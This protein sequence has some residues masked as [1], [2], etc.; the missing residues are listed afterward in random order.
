VRWERSRTDRDDGGRA[1]SKRRPAI[2][3]I[4]EAWKSSSRQNA[5]QT[6][7]E[8]SGSDPLGGN[9]DARAGAGKGRRAER[10]GDP[11][12]G[13]GYGGVPEVQRRAGQGGGS[14]REWSPIPELAGQARSVRRQEA[15]RHRRAICR[16]Q[17]TRRR[18]LAVAGAIS[19]RGPRVAQAGTLR[20]RGLRGPSDFGVR[21]NVRCSWHSD[22]A[23]AYRIVST[24]ALFSRGQA[25]SAVK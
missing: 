14:T 5:D 10:V 18:V 16:E 25:R 15:H 22:Q 3:C 1:M 11:P 9:K 13:G 8:A 6:F 17:G 20:R 2:R 12:D 7:Q 19:R 23:V 4:T 21:G 24:F